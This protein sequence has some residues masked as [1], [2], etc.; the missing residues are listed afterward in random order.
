MTPTTRHR[1]AVTLIE[2][3]IVALVIGILAAVTGPKLR[4]SMDSAQLRSAANV[5]L[6]DI[7]RARQYAMTQGAPQSV[8]FD[9]ANNT[10]TMAG[11]PDP[12]HPGQTFVVDLA[13]SAFAASIDS[14]AFG[15]SGTDTGVTFNALGRPNQGGWVY[16]SVSG[17]QQAILVSG[18]SGRAYLWP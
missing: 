9:A 2:L 3:T 1:R 6:A 14:V 13:A 17:N 15:V 7:E 12:D 5:V 16:V 4:S 10:Y 11:M 18:V 8:A